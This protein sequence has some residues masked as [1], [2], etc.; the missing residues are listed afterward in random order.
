MMVKRVTLSL[1]KD[2]HTYLKEESA[3]TGQTMGKILSDLV[4]RGLRATPEGQAALSSAQPQL[5]SV[6]NAVAP[7][8]G[9]S[10]DDQESYA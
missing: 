5:A 8:T 6:R 10:L 7:D 9:P 2:M 3:A 4:R 1:D